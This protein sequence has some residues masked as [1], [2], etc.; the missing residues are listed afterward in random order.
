MCCRS[1]QPV[2]ELTMCQKGLSSLTYLEIP[3]YIK[4]GIS[5]VVYANSW[6]LKDLNVNTI[7]AGR[8]TLTTHSH[9]CLRALRSQA[10]HLTKYV[11]TQNCTNTLK[12]AR[13]RDWSSKR[14]EPAKPWRT[15]LTGSTDRFDRCGVENHEDLE[16]RAR[17]GPR[18][19]LRS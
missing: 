5:I 7:H 14:P 11:L 6:Y 3:R 2:E 17:E 13:T 9:V 15:G 1:E 10:A 18:R 8:I 4:T 19:S 16:T 12:C